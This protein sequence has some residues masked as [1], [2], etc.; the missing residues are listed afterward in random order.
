MTIEEMQA[1]ERELWNKIKEHA[2]AI[3][4]IEQEWCELR[5]ELDRERLKAEVEAE[6]KEG[7]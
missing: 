1:R 7:K 3:S 6:M 4:P 2:K 5:R